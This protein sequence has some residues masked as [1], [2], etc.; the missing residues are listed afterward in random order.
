MTLEELIEKMTPQMHS[1]V[2]QAVELGKWPNG[3]V[4]DAEQREMCM[5][6]L[7]VYEGKRLPEEH[8]AGY[9]NTEK[10]EKTVCDDDEPQ[11]LQWVDKH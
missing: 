3:D 8:R 10:L 9:I 6:A 5:Q 2:R 4:L 11:N 1:V 7:I